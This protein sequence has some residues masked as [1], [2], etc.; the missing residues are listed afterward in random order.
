MAGHRRAFGEDIVP[1]AYDDFEQADLIVLTGSNTAWCHPILY[2]R[3]LAPRKKRGAKI[4][5]IDPRRTA[6]ADECDLHLALDPGMGPFSVT[7]QPN[8]MGGPE[9]GGFAN[10]LPAHMGFESPADVDR[11]ARF[12]RAPNIARRGGLKAVDLFQAAGDGR[13]KALWIMGTNP[14][15]SM[16]DAGRVRAALRACDFVAVS[17]VARTDTTRYA[18]VLLPAAAWGE[19][20]G[21]VTNSERRPADRPLALVHTVAGQAQRDSKS[22]QRSI[23]LL[24][25]RVGQGLELASG[26]LAHGTRGQSNVMAPSRYVTNPYSLPSSM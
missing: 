23:W 25:E 16:P 18:D 20:D 4:V 17:D 5:V 19:K 6:T 26:D 12:W 21:M 24:L 8:A 1:G 3:I 13:I 11:V 7:G 9:V 10:Q 22:P 15:A 2:Q 14:A